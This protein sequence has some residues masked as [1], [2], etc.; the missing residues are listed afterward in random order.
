MSGK[1]N[2]LRKKPGFAVL[3]VCTVYKYNV[4][5]SKSE[6]GFE[7]SLLLLIISSP[8]FS[9]TNKRR[10]QA[11]C[12]YRLDSRREKWIKNGPLFPFTLDDEDF[13]FKKLIPSSSSTYP[14]LIACVYL[15]L[16]WRVYLYLDGQVDGSISD[17]GHRVTTSWRTWKEIPRPLVSPFFDCLGITIPADSEKF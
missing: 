16:Y 2:V 5:W 17:R 6:P 10:I 13:R 4:T 15:F 9:H 3:C 11:T 12:A 1:E 7:L 14:A 8:F